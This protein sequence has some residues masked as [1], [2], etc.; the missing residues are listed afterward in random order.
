MSNDELKFEYME[1]AI[2][3]STH[4]HF[5]A[6]SALR[7]LAELVGCVGHPLSKLWKPE[8]GPPAGQHKW[9]NLEDKPIYQIIEERRID[10]ANEELMLYPPNNEAY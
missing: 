1:A 8:V 9:G 7:E 10:R 3:L 5:E 4:R 6:A 2:F